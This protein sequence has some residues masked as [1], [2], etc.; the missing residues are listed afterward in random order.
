MQGMAGGLSV[1]AAVVVTTRGPVAHAQGGPR[2]ARPSPA[3]Q[4]KTMRAD[5]RIRH[6]RITSSGSDAGDA[7]PTVNLHVER[8]REAGRWRTAVT[9]TGIDQP[10]VRSARGAARLDNPFLA[11]RLEYDE[12]DPAP[13]LYDRTGRIVELPSE[14]DRRRLGLPASLRRTTWD[15]DALASKVGSGFVPG[16]APADPTGLVVD[17]SRRDDRRQQLSRRYGGPEGRVRG[18]DRYLSSAGDETEEVL[19][20]PDAVL[21]VEVNTTR[22]GQL[23]SHVQFEYESDPTLGFVRRR[24]RAEQ[25]AGDAAGT[26][27]VTEIELT[28]LS[29]TSGGVE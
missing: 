20:A 26:R 19:V 6:G 11:T 17:A 10:E 8:R 3:A 7:A 23:I 16:A 29:V 2:A 4:G 25:L 14:L 5:L 18:F 27:L 28:N 1:I 9:L 22:Q 24:S 13:R 12:G 15:A 21:P